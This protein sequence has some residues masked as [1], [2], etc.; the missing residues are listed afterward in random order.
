MTK[1]EKAIAY[2]MKQRDIEVQMLNEMKNYIKS[3][4]KDYNKIREAHIEQIRLL[5]YMIARLS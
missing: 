4:D 2:L 3:T 1:Q 5:D